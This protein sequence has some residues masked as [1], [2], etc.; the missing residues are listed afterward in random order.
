MSFSTNVARSGTATG[1][2]SFLAP[3]ASAVAIGKTVVVVA[4]SVGTGATVNTLT[5]SKGNTWTPI[6]H[7]NTGASGNDAKAWR[8]T[9]TTALTTSDHLVVTVSG[10]NFSS[11]TVWADAF[12]GTVAPEGTPAFA[13]TA[14]SQAQ[15]QT[16]VSTKAG[17]LY[18]WAAEFLSSATSA[19]ISGAG[20]AQTAAFVTTSFANS[21]IAV[22]SDVTG[23]ATGNATVTWNGLGHTGWSLGLS[24]VAPGGGP[25]ANAGTDQTVVAGTQVTLDGTGSTGVGLSHAWTHVSG[26]SSIAAL[27]DPSVA[28]PT[29]TPTTSGVDVWRDTV[30]D[31]ASLTSSDTVSITASNRKP[32][33]LAP[34]QT[35]ATGTVVTLDGSASF[36]PD[37]GDTW[38]YA[39]TRISGPNGGLSSATD[40]KPTY[41]AANPGVDVWQLVVTDSHGTASDAVL[42]TITVGAGGVRLRVG[43]TWVSARFKARVNGAWV[44]A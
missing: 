35:V 2:A 36:D 27:S 14:A 5:D 7:T 12:D 10:S 21:A 17:T 43:P 4:L 44:D 32:V 39:W 20:W 16:V 28:Q 15:R 1:A 25:T 34:N 19:T 22:Y 41:T 18:V 40:P 42:C 3:V 37:S 33:A 6:D 23:A 13:A 31:S 29:Y 30:T 24:M 9:L 26:P 11:L 38:A 8:S